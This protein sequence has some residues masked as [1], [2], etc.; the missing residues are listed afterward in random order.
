MHTE[1]FLDCRSGCDTGLRLPLIL[2]E[3]FPSVKGK[4]ICLPNRKEPENSLL[5]CG[6]KRCTSPSTA[7]EL[8]QELWDGAA[9]PALTKSYCPARFQKSHAHLGGQT[10]VFL[11]CKP[12]MPAVWYETPGEQS[13][14]PGS[15]VQ[16]DKQP[17]HLNSENVLPLHLLPFIILEIPTIPTSFVMYLRISTTTKKKSYKKLQ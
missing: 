17:H 16:W 1:V 8:T 9:P 10:C 2:L 6:E 4:S 15:E 7:A 3:V 12:Q 14:W 13:R 5:S 11:T